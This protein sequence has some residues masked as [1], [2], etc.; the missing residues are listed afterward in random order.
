MQRGETR[1]SEHVRRVGLNEAVF[2]EVNERIE[3]LT[4]RFDV[5]QGELDLICEC[6]NADCTERIAMS[7]SDYEQLRSDPTLF[8]VVAGHEEPSA[9]DVV[10]SR[11]GIHIVRKP[12]GQPAEI[13]E[14]TDPRST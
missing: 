11:Q 7:V 5:G 2:R 4:R 10:A 9:E 13:A 1:L 6:G 8:A 14:Q 3:D 12:P